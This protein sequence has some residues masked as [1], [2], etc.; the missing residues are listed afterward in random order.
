MG[1]NNSER[2]SDTGHKTVLQ[3]VVSGLSVV[4]ASAV[5]LGTWKLRTDLDTYIENKAGTYKTSDEHILEI[6]RKEINV[7]RDRAK[8]REEELKDHIE[9]VMKY[10]QRRGAR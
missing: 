2:N 8:Q 6:V 1:R 10:Y 4:S 7:E 9:F 3:A 5:F